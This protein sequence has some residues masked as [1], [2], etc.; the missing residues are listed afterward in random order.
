MK[1]FEVMRHHIFRLLSKGLKKLMKRRKCSEMLTVGES[2]SG[3]SLYC[4]CNFSAS[5]TLLKKKK[6][7]HEPS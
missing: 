3:Y 1:Y 5:L 7:Q 2:E 6:P 4:S